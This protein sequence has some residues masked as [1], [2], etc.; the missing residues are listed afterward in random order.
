MRRVHVI[1]ALIASA[2]FVTSLPAQPR[3]GGVIALIGGTLIDGNGAAP[4][5]NSALVIENNRIKAVGKYGQVTI[6]AGATVI[7][8]TGMTVMP[9]LFE[10]HA[11]LMLVGHG[12]YAHW[13]SVYPGRQAKD[14]MPAA[15]KQALMHGITSVRDLGGPLE[16]LMEVKRMVD[17]GKIVGATVYTSGPFL[18]HEPYPNTEA[19]RWGV[20]G[21]A[22]ARAKVNKLADAGVC[23]IKLIDQD[24]MTME[25]VR[26]IVDE[27]HKRKIPVVAHAHRPDEVRRGLAAGVDDF[28][29]TGMAWAPEYPPDI[30]AALRE[31]TAQGNK[32]PLYWTPT[33]DV[34][35]NFNDRRNNSWYVNDPE[36][37]KWLPEDIAADVRNSLQRLDTLTYYRMVPNRKPTLD[38]KFLQLRESGVRLLIGTDAGVP[39]N[40]HGYATPQEMITW[41]KTYKM[42][43]ME[44]IRAATFW[45]ALALGVLDKVGTLEVGKIADVI[46]VSG[47]P[48]IDITAMTR[49]P[50]VIK[51]GQRVK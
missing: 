20:K 25:E 31:R 36:W 39:A 22:D 27:A 1:R 47:N 13:D 19:F 6:P 41:V 2:I 35:T 28:E 37:Y 26:A 33:I 29:H 46:A 24:E 49:V 30:I 15:V 12:N 50:I 5:V 3:A 43:P 4:I 44:T 21:V 45:P 32:A 34:L 17:S 23:C 42:D 10:S 9:G 14:I 51:N 7:N 18:Q 16:P 38:R 8:A 11:H 48:L 40:F